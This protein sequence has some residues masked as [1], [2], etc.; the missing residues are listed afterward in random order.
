[1]CG[2]GGGGGGG[3]CEGVVEI[4]RESNWALSAWSNTCIHIEY[5]SGYE[6]RGSPG[7]GRPP[8][9][10]GDPENQNRKP[11]HLLTGAT[12]V[13]A[14]Y[15]ERHHHMDQSEFSNCTVS[16]TPELTVGISVLRTGTSSYN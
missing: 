10:R 13:G 1:M 6:R 7:C 4:E 14:L 15:L 12:W 9:H 8:L 16:A 11:A 5:W 2:A 3:G